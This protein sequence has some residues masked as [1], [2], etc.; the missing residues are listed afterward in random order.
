[1][2][3]AGFVT[4]VIPRVAYAD[5]SQGTETLDNALSPDLE[6]T[7]KRIEGK[8]IAPCCFAQTV[9]NHYSDV[10]EHIKEQI[11]HM[12]AQGETEQ[13]IV[14]TYV[15][16][17]GERILAE[18]LARGFN[19]LAYLLPLLAVVAGVGGVILMLSRWQRIASENVAHVSSGSS[20]RGEAIP[21][22]RARLAE[23][24]A[25]FEG[26]PSCTASNEA[27]HGGIRAVQ[28]HVARRSPPD[29]NQP[30]LA[31]RPY[32]DDGQ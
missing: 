15:R 9:A 14:G 20:G 23:E 31:L 26:W 28:F 4:L 8:L 17:Y 1:M 21:R 32:G 5:E 30:R 16:V 6:A 7:A 11:R 25:R 2:V 19:W 24:L 10:A 18:P 22:L 29:D 12:L 3:Q 27:A 13:Q